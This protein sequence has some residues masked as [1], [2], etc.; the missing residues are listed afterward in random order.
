MSMRERLQDEFG[1]YL[2]ENGNIVCPAD[3][4]PRTYDKVEYANIKPLRRVAIFGSARTDKDSNLY[5][6]IREL[7]ADLSRDGWIIVTGGG[8]GSMEA[9]NQGAMDECVEGEVCSLAETI[10][11]PF[12]EFVNEHVQNR[13]HHEDFFTRLEKFA[14][15][16]DAFIITPGGVGTL[17]E[18][19]LV[20][21]LLQVDHIK[22]K[23]I[24]CV[25]RMWR[26]LR[27]W[28]ESEMV[29]S[30]FLG[31]DELELVHYVDRFAEAS[32]LLRGI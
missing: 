22:D 5:K 16:C 2:D 23:P 15:D 21:Q 26:S 6:A 19:A 31:A 12:E 13:K 24:I 25:G 18:L 32:V 14:L 11:L 10:R 3:E 27:D 20:Y 17:L 29:E 4:E 28:I 8:P 30:G 7:A 9:A 1:C